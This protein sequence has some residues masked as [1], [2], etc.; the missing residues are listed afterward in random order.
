MVPDDLAAA[1]AGDATAQEAWERLAPSHKKQYLYWIG[2]AKRPE[3]R[4]RRLA[5]T[6]RR[7]RE[8]AGR[9]PDPAAAAGAGVDGR[10]TSR[11][12]TASA[13]RRTS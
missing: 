7:V 13:S 1:L 9:E 10:A 8:G 4:A 12:Y 6:V 2:D 5:E 11:A 3:T